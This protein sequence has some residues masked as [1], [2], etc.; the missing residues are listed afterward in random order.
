[1]N[2]RRRAVR[3]G[4]PSSSLRSA[5]RS[6][7]PAYLE[8]RIAAAE[9]RA[10]G[11]V[12]MSLAPSCGRLSRGSKLL[13]AETVRP[14]GSKQGRSCYRPARRSARCRFPVGTL[15]GVLTVGAAQILLKNAGQVPSTPVWIAG[16]GPLP[17]LY[18][19]QL[20]NAGGRVA[21]FLDTTP[22][23]RWRTAL[24]HFPRALLGWRD[25]AKGV[26]LGQTA[27]PRRGSLRRRRL[28]YR[29]CRGGAVDGSA[30]PR[31]RR[32]LGDR[33]CRGSSGARRCGAERAFSALAAL[34]RRLGCIAGM[35]QAHRRC[36]GRV[37]QT[38]SFCRR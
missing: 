18:A 26:G 32:R 12:S 2:S 22:S 17:L 3:F 4:V 29:G 24:R 8:G 25:L 33:R 16:S 21:G 37:F 35:F 34:R 23:G 19:V 6:W 7:G 20:L 15:P 5:I 30:I 9:F 1:M 36:M 14:D 13:S 10:S 31:E 11:A 38:K 27:S 28:R